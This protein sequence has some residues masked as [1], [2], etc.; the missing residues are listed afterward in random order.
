MVRYRILLVVL[1]L[2]TIV[3]V[4]WSID[5]ALSAE[6]TVHLLGSS[7]IAIYI[8]FMVPLLTILRVTAG[9]LGFVMLASLGASTVLPDLGIENY[10]GHL[11]W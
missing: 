3:S 9:A 7:V 8:G 1:L 10:E 5:P 4:A 11:V 6:R 2:G